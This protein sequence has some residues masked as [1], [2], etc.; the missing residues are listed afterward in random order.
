MEHIPRFRMHPTRP[1]EYAELLRQRE[2]VVGKLLW[3]LEHVQV[4]TK[5]DTQ[6]K[7]LMREYRHTMRQ[8]EALEHAEEL[9]GMDIDAYLNPQP[10]MNHKPQNQKP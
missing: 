1:K 2:T 7:R 9:N 6:W 8:L 5:V 4:Q 3:V 10:Y